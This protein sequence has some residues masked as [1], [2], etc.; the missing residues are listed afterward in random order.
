M[1]ENDPSL[2]WAFINLSVL[3]EGVDLENIGIISHVAVAGG[4]TVSEPGILGLFGVGL[5]L[6]GFMR[7]RAIA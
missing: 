6:L 3:G 7:R 4:G 2:L 5:V 1:F